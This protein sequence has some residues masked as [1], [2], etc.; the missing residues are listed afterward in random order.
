MSRVRQASAQDDRLRADRETASW[1]RPS[2]SW[3]RARSGWVRSCSRRGRFHCP[4]EA[5]QSHQ[6]FSARGV[7]GAGFWQIQE[8]G[9]LA[10]VRF[11]REA[12]EPSGYRSLQ[13]A[14]EDSAHLEAAGSFGDQAL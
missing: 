2:P 1:V 13:L 7:S 11:G 4:P 9:V 3:P 5:A 8:V 12:S 10:W 6:R 14:R